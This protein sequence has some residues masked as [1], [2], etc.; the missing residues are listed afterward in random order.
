M[1]RWQVWSQRLGFD[2][3]SERNGEVR[4]GRGSDGHYEGEHRQIIS[5]IQ[6]QNMRLYGL[7]GSIDKAH[8]ERLAQDEQR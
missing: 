8:I 7:P 2:Q 6:L 1:V 3:G 5:L 4:G